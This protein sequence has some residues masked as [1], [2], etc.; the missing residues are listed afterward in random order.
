MA[1]FNGKSREVLLEEFKLEFLRVW[2]CSNRTYDP[3]RAVGYPTWKSLAKLFGLKT[4][5]E[6]L[7]HAGLSKYRKNCKE[8]LKF[9]ITERF[10]LGD[11]SPTH[12]FTTKP[13]GSW[14]QVKG[15]QGRTQEEEDYIAEQIEDYN[16]KYVVRRNARRQ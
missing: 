1:R 11:G 15:F 12:I 7:G 9:T 13:D 3:M 16:N 5:N 6:L 14:E 2:P 4:W 8:P 10:D